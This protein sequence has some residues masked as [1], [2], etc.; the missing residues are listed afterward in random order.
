VISTYLTDAIKTCEKALEKCASQPSSWQ[1]ACQSLGNILQG[2]AR[3]EEAIFWHSLALEE[4]PYLVEAYTNL[5]LLYAQ[6]KSWKEAVTSLRHAI[7]INPDRAEAYSYLAQIYSLH[8]RQEEGL[9]LWYKT[10]SLTPQKTDAKSHFNLAR[11]FQEKGKLNRAIDCYQQAIRKDKNFLAPYYEIANILTAE[12]Q[13]DR[14]I[15]YYQKIL[16]LDPNQ[17]LIHHKLGNIWLQQGQ[18]EDAIAAFRTTIQLIPDFPWAYRDLVKTFMQLEKWDEA[19]ATC[20]GII[21]LVREFPWVYAQMGNALLQKDCLDEAIACFQK[22]CAMRGWHHP[23]QRN[24]QFSQDYFSY[25]IPIWEPHLQHLVDRADVKAIEIGNTQAMSTCWLLDTILT[26]DSARLVCLEPQ[27]APEFDANIAK[28]EA[29]AKV[30]KLEGKIHQHLQ[31]LEANSYDLVNIQDKC[32]IPSHIRQDAT[33]AWSL[34]K[35]DGLL[36]FNDYKWQNPNK[37][38]NRPQIGIDEFLATIEAEYKI[39]HRDASAYQLIIQKVHC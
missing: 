33:L 36:I 15:K 5:G 25:R 38:E 1:E 26:H 13:L 18:F 19:L 16:E 37:P 24:Y 10:L 21:N 14:A 7:K 32:K 2:M 17:V 6:E 27:F 39:V 34:L 12:G 29:A 20:H 22:A 4:K 3:F 8:G 31:C 30:T 11:N 9:E 23:Q 28:T 35:M